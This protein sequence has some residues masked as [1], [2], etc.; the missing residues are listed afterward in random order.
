MKKQNLIL[1]GVLAGILGLGSMGTYKAGSGH[2]EVV[3]D[4]VKLVKT[5]TS[6][7]EEN[8]K[9]TTENKELKVATDSLITEGEQLKESVSTL[10]TKVG[11]YEVKMENVV[12][13]SNTDDEYSKPYTITIPIQEISDSTN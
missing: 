13:S 1:F 10:E 2:V 6:L 8:T 3:E 5:N 4:N 11:D 9:L 12:K 7:K